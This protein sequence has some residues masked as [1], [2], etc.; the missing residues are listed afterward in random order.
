[1]YERS[2]LMAADIY[3]KAFT[4]K[5]EWELASR[6]INHLRPG[7]FWP[8]KGVGR[9][10]M[11]SEHKGGILFDYWTSNPW[12]CQA[13]DRGLV[14]LGEG[15]RVAVDAATA[16]K[17]TSRTSC[18]S[19]STLLAA[20]DAAPRSS[21]TKSSFGEVQS[22]DKPPEPSSTSSTSSRSASCGE[23][24]RPLGYPRWLH[25]SPRTEKTKVEVN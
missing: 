12:A 15:P 2:A 24:K 22:I 11:L 25:L 21:S 4:G 3:T 19:A 1:M 9:S 17:A 7:D 20:Y 23:R 10:C 18:S 8:G 16:R 6:L 14:P 13:A 5:A